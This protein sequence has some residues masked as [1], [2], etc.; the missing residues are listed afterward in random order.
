LLQHT[1][2]ILESKKKTNGFSKRPECQEIIKT[3]REQWY[4]GHAMRHNCS[5][6][7]ISSH[8]GTLLGPK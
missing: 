3:G 5:E 6:K 1:P 7:E 8:N 2:G 4:L